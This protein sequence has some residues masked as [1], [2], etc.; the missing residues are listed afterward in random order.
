MEEEVTPTVGVTVTCPQEQLVSLSERRIALPLCRCTCFHNGGDSGFFKGWG[1][2]Q[3]SEACVL[4]SSEC[5]GSKSASRECVVV[6]AE[7]QKGGGAKATAG[8]RRASGAR[9]AGDKPRHHPLVS[10]SVSSLCSQD[11]YNVRGAEVCYLQPHEQALYYRQKVT[12][13][14][15]RKHD[16]GHINQ[17]PWKRR[18][19]MPIAPQV[20][21]KGPGLQITPVHR[22]SRRSM[23]LQGIAS[24]DS[25]LLLQAEK[26]A[27][28]GKHSIIGSKSC[29][30][31]TKK[32]Q[33]HD[34]RVCWAHSMK[35]RHHHNHPLPEG[36]L[37]KDGSSTK[38]AV[39]VQKGRMKHQ[40][41]HCRL[42]ML[43]YSP[44]LKG[45]V[46]GAG[47]FEGEEEVCNMPPLVDTTSDSETLLS[48]PLKCFPLS[49]SVVCK[50][51]KQESGSR[52]HEHPQKEKKN[53]KGKNS[54]RPVIPALGHTVH[55]VVYNSQ[56]PANLLQHRCQ[57]SF[58]G[59]KQ[60]FRYETLCLQGIG[61]SSSPITVVGPWITAAPPT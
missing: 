52:K 1:V 32:K 61:R 23:D 29:G 46:R 8:K 25:T 50:N 36:E 10:R 24:A 37:S 45:H 28:A 57:V 42:K 5:T 13:D 48:N 21:T 56:Q 12:Y 49:P 60:G 58:M 35:H 15:A 53:S 6:P 39:M 26:G 7:G 30:G 55:G 18:E 2:V 20:A 3:C 43:Q 41:K 44:G 47:L 27:T 11:L 38:R 59:M 31:G 33:E 16:V 54:N 40:F 4:T 9:S 51:Q 19:L 17:A 22:P 34:S 14:A